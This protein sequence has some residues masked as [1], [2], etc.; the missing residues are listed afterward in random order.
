MKSY[1]KYLKLFAILILIFVFI[2][3][4]YVVY[5]PEFININS[6]IPAIEKFFYKHTGLILS[7]D[8]VRLRTFRDFTFT[9]SADKVNIYDCNKRII[10]DSENPFIKVQP[11][12]FIFKKFKIKELKTDNLDIELVRYKNKLFNFDTDLLKNLKSP[13]NI[14]LS[15]SNIDISDY[16]ICFNDEFLNKFMFLQGSKFKTS[17]LSQK[18]TKLNAVGL[19]NIDGN[20]SSYDIEIISRFFLSKELNLEDY[21]SY[22]QIKNINLQGLAPYLE[23]I[24]HLKN[25]KGKIDI[26]FNS[27]LKKNKKNITEINIKANNLSVNEGDYE[28]Q[29]ILKAPLNI[30]MRISADKKTLF[31]EKFELKA[32]DILIKVNGLITDYGKQ[33]PFLNIQTEVS[34]SKVENLVN[35]IP[36]GICRELNL[37]KRYGISG[38]ISGKLKLTGRASKPKIYG[39]IEAK[40]VHALRGIERT[41]SA[42]INLDFDKTTLKTDIKL[43]ANNNQFFNLI[44]TGNI[45]DEDWNIFDISTSEDLD[46]WLVCKILTPVSEIFDFP[47]GP[48]PKLT[49]KSGTGSSKMHI[50]GKKNK[51]TD[52]RIDGYVKI[53]NGST[54]FEGIN[55]LIT[56]LNMDLLFE[57]EKLIFNSKTVKINGYG[58]N[59]SGKSDVNGQ[60]ELKIMANSI[61][62]TI[63]KS[64]INTSPV[65]DDVSAAIKSIKSIKGNIDAEVML[66]GVINNDS[67]EFDEEIKKLNTIGHI[68]LHN[69]SIVIK[70]YEVPLEKVIGKVCFTGYEAEGKS[71]KADIG[72]SSI[73]AD[74]KTLIS[75]NKKDT[76]T[77]IKVKGKKLNIKDT[78]RFIF[79]SEYGQGYGIVSYPK[80][81]SDIYHTLSLKCKLINDLIDINSLQAQ[82][83]IIPIH[84]INNSSAQGRISVSNGNIIFEKLQI[85]S[86]GIDLNIDGLI[87]NFG[88]LN[89]TANLYLR[90]R[91]ISVG[92]I[93]KLMD[94]MPVKY[95]NNLK[96]IKNL[97]GEMDFDV[98]FSKDGAEGK[99]NIENLKFNEIRTNIPFYTE[100]VMINLCGEKILLKDIKGFI[101]KE[102][103]VPITLDLEIENYKKIPIVRGDVDIT[104]NPSFIEN[105][106]NMTL[107]HPVKITGDININTKIYG[108][109]D[110]FKIYPTIK[111]N[112]DTDILYLSANLGD[113]EILRE[114]NGEITI[115]NKNIIIN[116]AEYIKYLESSE[117]KKNII[118]ILKVNGK[119]DRINTEFIPTEIA[120]ITFREIPAKMLNFLF[121][122]SLIKS[123]E[124]TCNIK[125]GFNKGIQK[126]FGNIYLENA[127][128]PMYN[129]T[130]IDGKIRANSEKIYI[131]ANGR[132]EDTNYTIRTEMSNSQKTPFN[133]HK[134]EVQ[135]KYLNLERLINVFN[136]WSIDAYMNTSLQSR[137]K[138]DI[139]DLMIERGFL[140]ADTIAYKTSPMKNFSADFSLDKNSLLNFSTK[141]FD[142]SG[143]K[144]S[145][146]VCYDFKSGTVKSILNV[147]QINSNSAAES[148]LGLK[149]QITGKLN[150]NV[151]ILTFGRNDLERLKNLQGKMTFN[152]KDGSMPKLGSIEYLLRA[153][154]IFQ[155]AL[156]TLSVNN[157]IELLKPFKTGNF[158]EIS[159]ELNINKGEINDISI[160]SQGNNLSIY[161]TGNYDIANINTD[162]IVYGK[163]GKKT[164][165]LLGPIGNFSANTIFSK[166]PRSK[167]S[168]EYLNE[169]NKIPNINYKDKD[170]RY[171]RATVKGDIN[172]DKVS[173]SFKWIK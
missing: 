5:L 115:N 88:T 130:I 116:N 22:G 170:V 119:I 15:A 9:L 83:N 31:I 89:P 61:N 41:H 112:K 94:L 17:L 143:G 102:R 87:E 105:N 46:L 159:G 161:I 120:V 111:I 47:I 149:N 85:D 27:I 77:E 144:V 45:Y 117:G 16:K 132:T 95:R 91:D 131:T 55:A 67:K 13:L 103:E 25:S 21:S 156:T 11:I 133:I 124:F 139:S 65:L 113:S 74:F 2:Q 63:L 129:S 79:S 171:F 140:K 122:K 78:L 14:D 53:K 114:I 118:P 152:I 34:N 151:E 109:I 84:K 29:F 52:T 148:F 163:L 145:G 23:D 70:G 162:V 24:V 157:V 43:K 101:G 135:T 107:S 86:S 164:E 62:S 90:G 166:I 168:K 8:N 80:I 160:M 54:V 146:K 73:S 35:I 64:I 76:T 42:D 49:V 12:Y 104:I 4:F 75:E 68:D 28:K 126:V 59:I 58:A 98:Y 3:I 18:L 153:T 71:I 138:F 125:Y 33:K 172:G 56:N 158:S 165:G 93:Y 1:I 108:S 142:M 147:L 137:V 92:V 82:I 19:L 150:G 123:G 40:K 167:N 81:Q 128:I 141:E 72:K 96:S 44:G 154:N 136:Q 121:K 100:K 48:I 155:S 26:S 106:V 50:K 30:F 69:N 60:I 66:K 169:I 6:K 110:S 7:V 39:K 57:K 97:A 10:L 99:I 173:T 36:Y 38:D 127:D 51:K 134:L 32:E 20:I 37:I